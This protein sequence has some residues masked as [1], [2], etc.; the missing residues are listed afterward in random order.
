MYTGIA[1]QGFVLSVVNHGERQYTEGERNHINKL[2]GFRSLAIEN[3]IHQR[4][5]SKEIF[6]IFQKDGVKIIKDQEVF[7]HLMNILLEVH[8]IQ[9][10]ILTLRCCYWKKNI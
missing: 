5:I 3:L 7:S 2:E 10:P 9:S 1:S 4:G 8:C 6:H